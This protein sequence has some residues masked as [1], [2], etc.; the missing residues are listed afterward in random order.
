MPFGFTAEEIK[1]YSRQIILKEIGGEGQRR[2]KD[3]NVLVVGAGGLGCPAGLYLAAAGIGKIGIVDKD[4]VDISNLQRQILHFTRDLGR[5][6]TESAAEKLIDLNPHV[7]VSPIQTELTPKNIKKI[8]EGYDFV[9]DGSDN[10][11]TKYMVNDACVAEGIPFSI[12]GILQYEGQMMTVVPG[13]S[14]CYRCVFPNPPPPGLIPSCQEA[15]VFG[16]LPGMFGSIQASEAIKYLTG[17]GELLIGRI[18]IVD[19]RSMF[20]D[21]IEVKKNPECEACG[22]NPIDLLKTFD[23]Y[24]YAVCPISGTT[25]EES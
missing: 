20:F 18:L 16:A 15:G 19:I 21:L 22:N 5:S 10:F 1:R 2:L 13:S 17:V 9:I 7:K 11:P 23:Y 8:L 25:H 12:A 14:P 6:K 24:K 4:K 3:S